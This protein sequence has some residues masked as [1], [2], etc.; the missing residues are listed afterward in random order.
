V[1]TGVPKKKTVRGSGFKFLRSSGGVVG[2]ADTPKDAKVLIGGDGA[3]EGEKQSG[4]GDRLG[5]KTVEEVG[6]CV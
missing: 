6:G 2:I 4:M 3:E 1:V 5:G